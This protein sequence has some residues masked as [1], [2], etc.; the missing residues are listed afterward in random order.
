MR[1]LEDVYVCVGVV[2]KITSCL[3]TGE[4]LV[5]H[6]YGKVVNSCGMREGMIK[7]V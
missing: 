2:M 7:L 3:R 4:C 6:W 1:R 5:H